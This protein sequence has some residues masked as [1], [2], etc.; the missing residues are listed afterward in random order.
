MLHVMGFEADFLLRN[1]LYFEVCITVLYMLDILYYNCNI[2]LLIL[3]WKTRHKVSMDEFYYCYYCGFYY[4]HY[5]FVFI[6]LWSK[7]VSWSR[8]SYKWEAFW[9]QIPSGKFCFFSLWWWL[10]EDSRLWIHN[11]YYARWKC[12]MELHC[13]TLWR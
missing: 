3:L 1:F 8:N 2:I 11:L 4:Q 6:S 9:R 7:W 13:P 12:S 10:C 5:Y